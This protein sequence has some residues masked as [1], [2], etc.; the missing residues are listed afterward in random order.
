MN[1]RDFGAFIDE[2]NE[3]I[4]LYRTYSVSLNCAIEKNGEMNL[5]GEPVQSSIRQE[6]VYRIKWL[7]KE[8]FDRL[9]EIIE[10]ANNCIKHL[11]LEEI[12]GIGSRFTP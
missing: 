10:S 3:L 12:E 6:I 11:K 1:E 5:L 4:S 9:Q 8:M 7:D 2:F